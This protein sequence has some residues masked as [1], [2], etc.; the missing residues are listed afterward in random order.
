MVLFQKF[1]ACPPMVSGRGLL[2]ERFPMNL[3]FNL[4]LVYSVLSWSSDVVENAA[5]DVG[6]LDGHRNGHRT[7]PVGKWIDLRHQYSTITI[8]SD[9]PVV[10]RMLEPPKPA[11]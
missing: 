10:S 6:R 9:V 5:T 3:F 11:L 4:H 2:I 1:E 7:G 8:R